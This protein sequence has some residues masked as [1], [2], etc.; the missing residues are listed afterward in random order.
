MLTEK[1][2]KCDLCVVG[3]G[4]SGMCAAISAAREGLQVVL[5]QERPVLGGN[6]SSEI[7]MWICGSHGRERFTAGF[8]SA[9]CT[10]SAVC[11]CKPCK[12]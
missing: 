3:G 4:I 1:Y 12:Q 9:Y 8:Y 5:M 10:K 2:I 11:A 6:A 7:R